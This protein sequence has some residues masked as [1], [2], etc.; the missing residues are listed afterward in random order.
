MAI[1][2]IFSLLEKISLIFV[3]AALAY[4]LPCIWISVFKKLTYSDTHDK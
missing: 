3:F 2:E 1:R 4:F